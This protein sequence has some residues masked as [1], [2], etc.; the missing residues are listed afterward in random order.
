MQMKSICGIMINQVEDFKYLGSYI[1]STKRYVNIRISK[2]WTSLN[3]M[4]IIWKSNP[5]THLKRNVII[6]AIESVI[7]YG[8]VT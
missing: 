1:R 6:A 2:V 7:V 8:S 4:N 3:S 5:S